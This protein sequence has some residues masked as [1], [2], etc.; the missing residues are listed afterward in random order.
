M[1]SLHWL[2]LAAIVLVLAAVFGTFNSLRRAQETHRRPLPPP[3]ALDTKNS[4]LDW[5]WGQSG[6]G[7]PQVHITAKDMRQS[8]DGNTAVL[9]DIELRLYSKEGDT[10]VRVRTSEAQFT[11]GENKLYSP[12]EA[13]ITL[14]VPV[15]GPPAHQLTSISTSGI[16]FDSKSGHAVSDQH[17]SFTFENGDGTCTG[18]DYDPSTHILN[19]NSNVVLNL[20]GS[21]KNSKPMKVETA[22]LIWDESQSVL[23]LLEWSRLTRDTAVI[24]AG[25]SRVQMK[26]KVLKA[27]D[28]PNGHGADKQPDKN[29]EYSAEFIHVDFNDDGKMESLNAI[30]NAKLVS[31][32][33]ASETTITGHQVD[34]KFDDQGNL[35]DVKTSGNGDLESKPVAMGPDAAD[36]RVVKSDSIYL[37]M[38]QGGK[39]IDRINTLAPG[40]LEIVPNQSAR[41]RRLLKADRF[42]MI[43]GPKNEI[44]EFHANGTPAVPA[45][46]E[47]QPSAEERA[48]KNASPAV[49]YTTSRDIDATFDDKGELKRMAQRTGFRYTQGVRRAQADNAVLENDRN[50]MDLDS[51]ARIQDDTGTTMADRIRIDQA[52]GDFDAKDHVFTTRLPDQ[53]RSEDS[54]PDSGVIDNDQP[55][56]GTADHVISTNHNRL[57]HYI[58][59][60]VL[61]Q[62]ANRIQ[63]D[64]V[65]ID[66]EKKTVVADGK[67]ITQFQDQPK[68][69]EPPPPTPIF[70]LVKSEKMTYADADLLANYS[71]GV[72]FRR[73]GLTVTSATL[74]AFL[75]PKDSGKDSR[76]NRALSDGRVEITEVTPLHHRIGQGEH[77]EYYTD[78]GKVV[79]TGGSPQLR[80]TV[81][82]NSKGDTLTYFTNDN[83]LIIDGVPERQVQSHIKKK[84]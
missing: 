45:S 12:G 28:A 34:L 73:P 75:N 6:N 53:K 17:V 60:A 4:A 82:G 55:V 37:H 3:I 43:Y 30:G 51:H 18:A 5:E 13:E 41:H 49:A 7:L 25:Q 36:T 61:W 58:G 50:Q 66:R 40:S 19:L 14:D 71:G 11:T 22:R 83:R 62:P 26:D 65:D 10:Y 24:D 20:R 33:P 63:S 76:V 80:D 78:D 64:R 44:Q 39:E 56:Q 42:Q 74:K 16:N 38:K 57:I 84:K 35:S 27:I 15:N 47:T 68:E 2:L 1:R 69:G 77:A 81:R 29:I 32:A 21:G 72:D 70:T 67:V 46:T 8:T 48:K 9:K 54:K 59:H 23:T 79:L 31:H 52:T